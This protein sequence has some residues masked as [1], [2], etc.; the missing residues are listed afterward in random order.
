MAVVSYPGV[1]VE[2][3]SSGVR[4]IAAASTS[5]AAFIG[6][7]QKGSLTEAVR[8]FNFTQFQ[9]LYGDFIPGSY[10]AHSVYQFFN[11][12]GSQCYIVRVS[13]A[14]TRVANIVINDRAVAAEASLTIEAVSP[15]FWGN[16]IEIRIT[17]GTIDPGNEFNM[18]VYMG[19][20]IAPRERFENLSMV[21]DISNFVENITGGSNYVRVAV[22]NAN[23][24]AT[25]GLSIGA[26]APVEPVGV[27]RRF[28]INIDGDGYQEINLTDVLDL[29][30]DPVVNISIK[31]TPTDVTVDALDT[32]NKIAAAIHLAVRGN[33][34]SL[35]GLTKIKN[36][37]AA[38]AFSSFAAAVVTVDIDG[39]PTD[40]L[41]LSSGTTIPGSSV[42]VAP[43]SNSSNDATGFLRLGKLQGGTEI[44]GGAV[45]RPL[46]NTDTGPDPIPRYLVGDHDD[47]V[48]PVVS[49][50]DG[51]DGDSVTD[52]DYINAFPRLDNIDDVS[53]IAVP[54]IG[55]STVVSAGMNYCENR[56]LSDCF[57]IGD[58]AQSDD[59]VEEARNF[60]SNLSP[61]NSY[62]AVYM[63][64]LLALD[65]T[66]VSAE[67]IS[68]P[69]SGYVVGM[70][71]KTDAKRGVWKAPAGTG[72][73][74]A[75]A[76]GLVVNLTDVEHGLL[77]PSP[78]DINVIRQFAASGRVIWGARTQTT[79]PEWRY[80]PVRRT[81]IMLRVSIYNGIQ[82]AVF[83]PND[84]ELWSQLRLNIGSFMM[85]LFR[86]GAFQGA[87]PSQ[88]FFVKCDS[89]TTTQDDINLGIV[90]V[91]IGFAPLKPAEFVVVKISQ[92]AGQSS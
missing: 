89:E 35:P 21:P 81:A 91:L 63:P 80:V 55:L 34:G 29:A 17:N 13:G 5:T 38:A 51:F 28:R 12:G 61:K 19:D 48:A 9:N 66:G 68:V 70:Y 74:L 86:Q 25:N 67:P 14:N 58:M 15:G 36:S 46:A 53:L 27:Q 22:N 40:V 59:T 16:N 49:V 83:E 79:D 11:N 45:T 1:Y 39:T 87:T 32:T 75:G 3:V 41:Q 2:E 73:G 30:P 65:P 7:A 37:T 26:D 84:E 6:Q 85:T 69:P 47:S 71:A 4:P 20:E 42:N 90:N 62:G 82:W 43:A 10:L 24:H 18:E 78:H 52:S 72:A 44:L 92:K 8:V 33:G 64:W 77:N 88:A 60:V 57:F 54:G 56:S 76:T 50:Q 31:G 23:T